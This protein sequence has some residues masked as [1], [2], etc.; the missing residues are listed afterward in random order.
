[1]LAPEGLRGSRLSPGLFA[2]LA[3]L[4]FFFHLTPVDFPRLSIPLPSF[5][6]LFLSPPMSPHFLTTLSAPSTWH[7]TDL[8]NK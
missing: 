1:M 3:L 7:S 8:L 4:L 5:F 6:H 2:S